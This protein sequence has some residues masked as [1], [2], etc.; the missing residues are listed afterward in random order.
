M[1]LGVAHD[2]YIW[3]SRLIKKTLLIFTPTLPFLSTQIIGIACFNNMCLKVWCESVDRKLPLSREMREGNN[4]SREIDR[5]DHW[6]YCGNGFAQ[7]NI[8]GDQKGSANL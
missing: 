8:V 6:A 2:Y 5:V 1:K 3:E 7:A 4:K